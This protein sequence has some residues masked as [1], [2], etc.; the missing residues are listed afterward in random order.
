MAVP[1]LK[2]MGFN[3][4]LFQN[5]TAGEGVNFNAYNI[6]GPLVP[7]HFGIKPRKGASPFSSSRRK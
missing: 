7:F 1:T 3:A 2:A 4:F 6:K 5:E